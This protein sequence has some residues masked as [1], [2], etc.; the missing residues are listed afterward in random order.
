MII[1][2]LRLEDMSLS[3]AAEL[4]IYRN[5]IPEKKKNAELQVSGSFLFFRTIILVWEAIISQDF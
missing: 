2:N 4:T 3:E 1:F 5:V